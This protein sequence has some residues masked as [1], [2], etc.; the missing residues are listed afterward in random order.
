[1]AG[2]SGRGALGIAMAVALWSCID[3]TGLEEPAPATRYG[4][5]S[6]ADLA[7]DPHVVEVNLRAS[8]QPG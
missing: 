6:F 4:I 2:V 3:A 5:A 8:H 1:M 7:A